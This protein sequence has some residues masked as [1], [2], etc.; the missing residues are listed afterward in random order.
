MPYKAKIREPFFLLSYQ[1]NTRLTTLQ[2]ACFYTLKGGLLQ[3]ERTA[4]ADTEIRQPE[5]VI[6]RPRVNQY[7]GLQRDIIE[8]NFPRNSSLITK[9]HNPLHINILQRDELSFQLIT[10]RALPLPTSHISVFLKPCDELKNEL[11][12][13]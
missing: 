10:C 8:K 11:I 3:C 13:S 7:H 9:A 12:T 5:S 2:K 4:F 1:D 6:S